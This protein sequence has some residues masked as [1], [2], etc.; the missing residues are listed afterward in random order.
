MHNIYGGVILS[1]IDE[2]LKD[3]EKLRN[4]MQ[5][6]INRKSGNLTD[7]EVVTASKTLNTALNTY[8]ELLEKKINKQ[9]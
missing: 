3:I 2:L 4:N 6:L 1:E 5:Q 9:D 8:N 7:P